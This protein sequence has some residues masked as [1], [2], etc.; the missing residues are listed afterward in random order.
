MWWIL[1]TAQSMNLQINHM[2]IILK[3]IISMIYIIQ[4]S[5][6]LFHIISA[7]INSVAEIF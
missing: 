1:L 7:T 5:T 3:K 4:P 6:T 2:G